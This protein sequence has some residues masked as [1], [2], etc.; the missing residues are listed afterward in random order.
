MFR[1]YVPLWDT[2]S[3]K[4]QEWRKK[5]LWTL[6]ANDCLEINLEG[7]KKLYKHLHHKTRKAIN[8]KE[9]MTFMQNG[10]TLKRK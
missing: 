5:Q 8:N 10:A 7:L 9:A 4:V 2:A 3:F 1:D 6:E